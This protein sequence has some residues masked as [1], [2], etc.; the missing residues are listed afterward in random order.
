MLNML[1]DFPPAQSAA[2][3]TLN[4]L[5]VLVDSRLES[6]MSNGSRREFQLCLDILLMVL[7]TWLDLDRPV[8]SQTVILAIQETL[9]AP[10]VEFS[11]DD[12]VTCMESLIPVI[13]E[14]KGLENALSWAEIKKLVLDIFTSVSTRFFSRAHE[15]DSWRGRSGVSDE[16]REVWQQELEDFKSLVDSTIVF[17][18][19]AASFWPLDI[20]RLDHDDA[21][22]QLVTWLDRSWRNDGSNEYLLR[23]VPCPEARMA[24]YALGNLMDSDA[25]AEALAHYQDNRIVIA[26]VDITVHGRGASLKEAA[27][28]LLGNLAVAKENRLCLTNFGSFRAVKAL[29]YVKKPVWNFA[30]DWGEQRSEQ[31]IALIYQGTRLLGLLLRDCPKNIL[32]F[33]D[34]GNTNESSPQ[35]FIA[36]VEWTMQEVQIRGAS[37]LKSKLG[38]EVMTVLL[39]ILREVPGMKLDAVQNFVLASII[40]NPHVSSMLLWQA[41]N[42]DPGI[43]SRVYMALALLT[44]DPAAAKT[45]W[46]TCLS[47][48][49]LGRP[50]MVTLLRVD[51]AES[52]VAG[53]FPDKDH[54]NVAVMVANL[55]SA[56]VR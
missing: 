42:P 43:K 46:T 20:N 18:G 2:A 11:Q 53:A 48:P 54:A 44:K 7:P 15:L 27:A 47:T 38:A 10:G 9:R 32:R 1:R 28:S 24:A 13:Q 25:K 21:L 31:R 26:A 49:K 16:Y 51:N 37:R 34:A 50:T 29:L 19:S 5:D 8:P 23:T 52:S 3:T 45:L 39:M 12:F 55:L 14:V 36:V 40:T 17:A 6:I 22:H 41:D 30:F 4:M 56:E 33:L 35:R